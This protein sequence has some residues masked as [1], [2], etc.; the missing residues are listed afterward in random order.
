MK[1]YSIDNLNNLLLLYIYKVE[2]LIFFSFKLLYI[3]GEGFLVLDYKMLQYFIFIFFVIGTT[4]V[5]FFFQIRGR[6]GNGG[7]Y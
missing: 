6:R 3:I 2:L 7:W 5:N 4:L 1:V